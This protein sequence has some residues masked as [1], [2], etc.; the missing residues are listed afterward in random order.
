VIEE[1]K[2]GKRRVIPNRCGTPQGGVISPLLANIYLNGLDW[3][4]N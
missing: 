3:E 4:I 1:D 2:V